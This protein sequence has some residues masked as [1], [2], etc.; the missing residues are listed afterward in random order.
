MLLSVARVSKLFG[1]E[2]GVMVS[3]Y[4]TFPDNF[5]TEEPLFAKIDS[6][7]VPL[8]CDKFDRRGTSSAVVTFADID[9]ERRITEFVGKELFLEQDEEADEEFYMED[10]IGFKV[11][12]QGLEGEISD[13][14]DSE[15]N[16]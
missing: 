15:A 6:L 13:Y 7:A 3:L 4:T 12:A 14:F 2:G 9:S 11:S 10:L 1:V 16:P 5:S 8:F